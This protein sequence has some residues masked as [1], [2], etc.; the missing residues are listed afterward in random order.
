MSLP[1][2]S[3]HNRSAFTLIELLVVVAIIALLISILLPSLTEAR[4]TARMIRCQANA[5]QFLTAHQMY[6][7]QNDDWFVPHSVGAPPNGTGLAWYRH[8]VYR[9][10]LGLRPGNNYPEGLFCPSIPPDARSTMPRYNLGGNGE[11]TNTP[12]TTGRPVRERDVRYDPADYGATGTAGSD[13]VLRRHL[14]GKIVVP[15][16]KLQLVDGSD[17][18]LSQ[19]GANWTTRWD[20]VPETD[21]GSNPGWGAPAGG[22]HNATAYRHK[23]GASV[24]F[25][26]GHA[27]YRPKNQ[28]FMINPDGTTNGTFNARLWR[29]YRKN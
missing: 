14:R 29:I 9:N 11:A 12:D 20:I 3:G 13:G 17:W 5:K 19:G 1:H 23:E 21:G 15:S 22:F 28:V 10:M 6:A 26:D 8:I 7:N 27:E 2:V 25:F 16:E 24:G 18:N 4:N